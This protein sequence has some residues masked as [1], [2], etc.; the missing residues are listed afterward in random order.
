MTISNRYK[1]WVGYAQAN[2]SMVA[3]WPFLFLPEPSPV[4][5]THGVQMSRSR[6]LCLTFHHRLRGV[7]V[8][9]RAEA[10]GRDRATATPP[11]RASNQQGNE[12]RPGIIVSLPHVWMESRAV[13]HPRPRSSTRRASEL[14]ASAD[15]SCTLAVCRVLP[16]CDCLARAKIWAAV[17]QYSSSL[18]ED[19]EGWK[20]ATT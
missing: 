2:V 1:W 5:S 15:G 18:P 20:L 10:N 6:S 4:R 13:P 16:A 17:G 11:A 8:F 3:R 12:N 14:S 19:P 7:P 9:I